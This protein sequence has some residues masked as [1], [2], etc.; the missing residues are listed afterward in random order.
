MQAIGEPTHEALLTQMGFVTVTTVPAVSHPFSMR[1][2]S[3]ENL[4][5]CICLHTRLPEW[6]GCL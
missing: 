3:I 6:E 4:S 2:G 5:A 1:S